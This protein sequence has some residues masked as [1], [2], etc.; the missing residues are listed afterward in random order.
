[1]MNVANREVFSNL[2]RQ[3]PQVEQNIKVLLKIKLV[4]E[5]ILSPSGSQI[6]PV[7]FKLDPDWVKLGPNWTPFGSIPLAP[8]GAHC[9]PG[10]IWGPREL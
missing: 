3:T 9:V 4:C 10:P 7:G 1:M 8:L 5:Y 6:R 2:F